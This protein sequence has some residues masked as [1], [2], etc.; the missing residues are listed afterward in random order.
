MDAVQTHFYTINQQQ[1]RDGIWDTGWRSL[2]NVLLERPQQG[3]WQCQWSGGSLCIDD[4]QL[5][6]VP[7]ACRHRLYKEDPAPM[8]SDWSYVSWQIVGVQDV[9]TGDEPQV[10]SAAFALEVADCFAPQTDAMTALHAQAAS[11]RI[12]AAVLRRR[13]QAAQADE[14][15]QKVIRY[16]HEHLHQDITRDDLATV[17]H[18]SPTRFH[19][20]FVSA[21]GVA[22]MRYLNRLRMQRAQGLLRGSD[23]SIGNIARRCGFQSQAYFNR[24]FKQAFGRTPGA[25]R[26][27]S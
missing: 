27:G 19:D 4:G 17:C 11:L 18:L 10:F 6:V 3:S 25:F 22:P 5:L 1:S 7:V 24:V 16:M 8:Y 2:P 14:R 26:Q 20:V 12:L 15:M 13:P 23:D 9:R 21:T